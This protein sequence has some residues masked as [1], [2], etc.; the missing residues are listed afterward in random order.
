M[1]LLHGFC[2]LG[3][4]SQVSIDKVEQAFEHINLD[5]GLANSSMSRNTYVLE[6]KNVQLP[7]LEIFFFS[8]SFYF[9]EYTFYSVSC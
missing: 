4:L 2:S 5:H 9:L 3:H 7:E 8:N 1:R 6:R